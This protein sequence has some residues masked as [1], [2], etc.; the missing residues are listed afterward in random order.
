MQKYCNSLSFLKRIFVLV[1]VFCILLKTNTSEAATLSFSPSST[2][3]SEGN[4]VSIRVSTNTLGKSVNNAEA[5]IQFPTDLLEVV[6]VNKSSSIFSL[7]VE[8][9]KFS[10]VAGTVSFNGGISNPGYIG[11]NGT[12]ATITFKA[13]KSGVATVLFADAAVR[14][15][16]GLGTDILSGRGT[17]V[18]QISGPKETE[19]PTPTTP[20]STTKDTKPSKPI[21]TSD[22]HP[23]QNS[24]YSNSTASFNWK[25]PSG[26]NS[27]QAFTNRIPESVPTTTYDSSVTQKTLTELPDGTFYFH[28]RYSNSSGWGPITHYKIRVDT[29]SPETFTPIVKTV[30]NQSVIE[31]RAEDVTSGIDYYTVKIDEGEIIKIK[32][33]DLVNFEYVLPV[34][35]QG[36]HIVTVVAYD[37]AGNHTE[38]VTNFTSS[39]ITPPSISL[40][41]SEIKKGDPVIIF[42]KSDYPN[43]QVEVTF[44]LFGVE[45]KKYIGDIGS[46]GSF[47]LTVDN[48]RKV[49]SIKVSAKNILSDLVKSQPSEALDLRVIKGD[50]AKVTVTLFW[51]V[52]A[53]A[54][55]VLLLIVL[56]IGWY[57]FLALKKKNKSKLQNAI[58]DAHRA[59]VLLKEELNDQLVELEK[60]RVDRELNKNEEMVFKEI[61]KNID[62]VDK[63][64]EKKLKKLM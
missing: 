12:L 45:I 15:N 34:M 37:K 40:S 33:D 51:I 50:F 32:K 58:E 5:T 48:V 24:W 30:N 1:F 2:N 61:Q 63:F 11:S 60:V 18:I 59:V 4:I 17:S 47:S 43:K 8:E 19:T 23:D 27:V 54:L 10:N 6:S 16:D 25:T 39:F 31:L 20:V 35:A 21:V 13:K 44:E 56:Y 3:I 36:E 57:K 53:V 49:G 22:T 9:P 62:D 46:D 55:L 29:K 7:W 14:E 28:I 64:I 38:A 52:L 41:S 26:I 42:G